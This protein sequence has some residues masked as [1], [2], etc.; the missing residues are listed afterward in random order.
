MKQNLFLTLTALLACSMLLT[1]CDFNAASD[2]FDD[3]NI[4][5]GIEN[6]KT[7]VT[8]QLFDARTGEFIERPATVEFVGDPALFVDAFGDPVSRIRTSI[9]EAVFSISDARMPSEASPLEFG[10]RITADGYLPLFQPIVLPDTGDY[11]LSFSLLDH[12]APPLGVITSRE[13]VS[14]NAQGQTGSRVAV[15]PPPTATGPVAGADLPAGTTMTLSSG[16]PATG[17]V[18][19]GV[20]AIDPTSSAMTSLP[21]SRA[22]LRKSNDLDLDDYLIFGAITLD[23]RTAQGLNVAAAQAPAGQEIVVQLSLPFAL[24]DPAS[25]SNRPYPNGTSFIVGRFNPTT[26]SYETFAQ[27][28]YV[29]TTEGAT[30][31]YALRMARTTVSAGTY[32]M[33]AEIGQDRSEE[34]TVSTSPYRGGVNVTIEQAY[35]LPVTRIIPR[36]SYETTAR[37][38]TYG[39]D[40]RTVTVEARNGI[41]FDSGGKTRYSVPPRGIISNPDLTIKIFFECPAGKG[42][43]LSVLPSLFLS[44]TRQIIM[45][46]R[47]W[48][49]FGDISRHP[50]LTVNRERP[51]DITSKITSV[52]FVTDDLV[53]GRPYRFRIVYN[54][55]E[56]YSVVQTLTS[57]PAVLTINPGTL[58]R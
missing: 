43:Y 22:A 44:Y 56:S 25:S 9:G 41:F 57:N 31:R 37:V 7:A 45:D 33:L 19:I 55:S 1:A 39:R 50:L 36:N 42:V 29:V 47:P 26:D 35:R 20:T 21:R 54:G 11:G 49:R 16:Q 18:D 27:A 51:G 52:Q 14:T 5:L 8:V 32:V 4:V 30:E 40:T 53:T 24:S 28:T 23:F 2:A 6:Q 13:T 12:A 15:T 46:T 17:S 38:S 58:C 48:S 34:V 3:F 10:V